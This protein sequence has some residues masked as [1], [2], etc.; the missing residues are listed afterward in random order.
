MVGATP[1]KLDLTAHVD[2]EGRLTSS[3]QHQQ[4]TECLKSFADSRCRIRI[5][6]STRTLD[7]NSYM[8]AIF[9]GVADFFF[10]A[11]IRDHAG[12]KITTEAWKMYFKNKHGLTKFV[13]LHEENEPVEVSV[14]TAKYNR[15]DMT[16]FIEKVRH[17]DLILDSGFYVMTPEEFKKGVAREAE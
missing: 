8:H 14:S 1:M 11:G 10:E 2:S 13:N 6:S 4:V 17:D 12:E 5:E 9:A 15:K 16:E 7:Q 3:F